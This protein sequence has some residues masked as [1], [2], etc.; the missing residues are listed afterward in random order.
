MGAKKNSS[1]E[2]ISK[3][4]EMKIKAGTAIGKTAVEILR[5]KVNEFRGD[6]SLLLIKEL[7]STGKRIISIKP[8]MA[9]VANVVDRILSLSEDL[10]E[11]DA[12][13]SEIKQKINLWA[14]SYFK[15]S[16]NALK[17][18]SIYGSKLLSSSSVIFTHSYSE[19]IFEIFKRVKSLQ[20]KFR[21]ICTES[22]P[23]LEGREFA[24]NLSNLGIE[25]NLIIDALSASFIRQADIVLVGCDAIYIDGSIINKA[26]TFLVS[27][28][29]HKFDV[30][31]YVAA[32]SSK[33]YPFSSYGM[34]L[35]LEER[36]EKE[37]LGD[38]RIPKDIP[39]KVTNQFFELIPHHY[40]RGFITENGIYHPGAIRSLLK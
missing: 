26:G 13:I 23:L 36:P 9:P 8:S 7:K 24:I 27:I 29:A 19:S 40:I 31:L 34:L 22:R 20:K 25:T 35:P 18:I 1:E 17:D 33:I 6:N 38:L 16:E 39:L 32:E 12:S 4:K 5:L 37:V 14:E 15:V 3:I 10:L 11:K 28:L 2:L 30:P 21:V